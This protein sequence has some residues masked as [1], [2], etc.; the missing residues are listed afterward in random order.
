MKDK[1]D[2]KPLAQLADELKHIVEANRG[3][4]NKPVVFITKAYRIVAELAKVNTD[5]IIKYPSMA[6]GALLSLMAACNDI[7]RLNSVMEEE[8][9]HLES[10]DK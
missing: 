1:N 5:E 7:A 6:S 2:K 3:N 10:E 8:P 4:I 9:K